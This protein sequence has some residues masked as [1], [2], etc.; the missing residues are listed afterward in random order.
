MKKK[1]IFGS[2]FAVAI[3]LILPAIPAVELNEIEEAFE[4]NFI[5]ELKNIEL[6]ELTEWINC[7][8][9][10]FNN[11]KIDEEQILLVQKQISSFKFENELQELKEKLED[12][13]VQPQCIIFSLLFL[14]VLTK[15]VCK[16]IGGIIGLFF[17]MV[18]L[19]LGFIGKIIGFIGG[20]IG[21]VFG[22]FGTILGWFFGTIGRFIGWIVEIIVPG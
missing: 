6:K 16:V 17:G 5:S 4:S 1:L 7:Q 15:L 14:I 10:A 2:F 11:V 22:L 20:V 8:T 3:I 9:K 19:I 13:N 18:G 12:E 21:I